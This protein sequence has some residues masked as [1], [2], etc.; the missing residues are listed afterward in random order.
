M[1]R[2]IAMTAVIAGCIAAA[3]AFGG[4]FRCAEHCR[5]VSSGTNLD[6]QSAGAVGNADLTAASTRA[7]SIAAC[8]WAKPGAPPKARIRMVKIARMAASPISA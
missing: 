7:G 2:F 8:C 1:K 3:T 5:M 6:C 4:A